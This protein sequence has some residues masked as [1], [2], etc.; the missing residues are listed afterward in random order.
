MNAHVERFDRTIQEE[1]IDY[2]Q[3]ALA[4]PDQF[5]RQRIPWLLWYNA[6]RPHWALKLSSSVQFLLKQNPTLCNSCRPIQVPDVLK[7]EA[8][9]NK[10][11]K[12]VLR[13]MMVNNTA[14]EPVTVA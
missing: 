13:L 9:S 1:F 5:N 11:P 10:K 12:R 14:L 3:R 6:E 2:H 4:L 7:E 8:P